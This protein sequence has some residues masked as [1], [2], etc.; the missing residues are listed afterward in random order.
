MPPVGGA[1]NAA[2]LGGRI[3]RETSLAGTRASPSV[4]T[5]F[6]VPGSRPPRVK[7]G[8]AY[9]RPGKVKKNII[10]SLSP[11]EMLVAVPCASYP[12]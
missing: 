5:P 2:I 6:A 9:W 1:L 12:M 7:V 10:A 11:V 4:P 3:R 8:N